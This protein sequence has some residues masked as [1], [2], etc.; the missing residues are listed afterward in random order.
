[1]SRIQIVLIVAIVAL[2]GLFLYAAWK[3]GGGNE[4]TKALIKEIHANIHQGSTR[5]EI[6]SYLRRRGAT[7]S[8][9]PAPDENSPALMRATLFNVRQVGKKHQNL[10]MEFWFDPTDHIQSY[11]ID[12]EL[13]D[14]NARPTPVFHSVPSATPVEGEPGSSAAVPAPES[15]SSGAAAEPTPDISPETSPTPA[16]EPTPES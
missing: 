16:A 9:E 5:E 3:S 2:G 6:E 4:Q 14:E 7:T 12:P 11:T 13:V 8:F 1:M 10:K 15:G